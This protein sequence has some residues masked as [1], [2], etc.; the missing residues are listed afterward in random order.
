MVEVGGA[1]KLKVI[2]FLKQRTPSLFIPLAWGMP[3]TLPM[4]RLHFLDA[5]VEP[6]PE[7]AQKRW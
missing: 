3:D 2:M 5:R 7:V 4:Q 6:Q 1:C